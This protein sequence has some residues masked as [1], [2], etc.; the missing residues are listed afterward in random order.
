MTE[1]G[2]SVRT[3][4][5]HAMQ[6]RHR[7][8]LALSLALAL[9]QGCESD[10]QTPLVFKDLATL[11]GSEWVLDSI[12]GA[13]RLLGTNVTLTFEDDGKAGGYGG[14]NW[15][16]GPYTAKDSAIKFADIASTMRACV[17]PAG[18]MEQEAA[19]HKA[20]REA[21]WYRG[22]EVRL[23]FMGTGAKPTLVFKR[24]IPLAMNPVDLV[25]SHWRLISIDDTARGGDS[26]TIDFA[27]DTATGFAGCRNFTST[28][29]AY[30]DHL[31]FNSTTMAQTEC[32]RGDSVTLREGDFTTAL[33]ET[34]NYRLAQ[35]LL[36]LYT[37][38]GGRLVFSRR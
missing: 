35:D 24:R 38:S 30:G 5:G 18:A 32:P 27:R 15:Y 14:C 4:G 2:K 31:R 33:S 17:S 7:A 25:G 12:E 23:T 22:T 34:T 36:E 20:L 1:R 21:T 16:G 28:F 19:L 8:M 10:D 6:G 9:V 11:K 29:H 13:P 3:K 26:V 37:V